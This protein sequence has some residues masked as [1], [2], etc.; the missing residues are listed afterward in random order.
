MVLR[1]M[2]VLFVKMKAS[3]LARTSNPLD[4]I[5][6]VQSLDRPHQLGQLLQVGDGHL[7]GVH[8]PVVAGGAAVRLGD[9]HPLLRES[10]RDLGE[11]ARAIGGEHAQS[12]RPLEIAAHVPLDVHPAL[13]VGGERLLAA[14]MVH[15]YPS[16]P[17]DESSDRIAGDRI[18]TP[19]E[20]HQDIV[21]P[22]DLYP[23]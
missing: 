19:S 18:A 14:H 1:D 17:G 15:R 8:R 12:D 3:T 13:R 6:A 10:V 4:R 7:E 16:A 22:A 20:A 23:A 5:N 2:A 21:Y 11:E 9:V